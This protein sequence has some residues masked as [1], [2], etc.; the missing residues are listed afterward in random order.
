MACTEQSKPISTTTAKPPVAPARPVTDTYFGAQVTDP[1]RYMENLN[2]PEVQAWIKGQADYARHVLDSLPDRNVLLARIRELDAGAPYR[3]SIVHR[4]PNGD[5][6]YLKTMAKE[7][8]AKLYWKDGKTGEEKLLVDPEKWSQ[9]G[10]HFALEFCR[11]SPDGKFVAY[12]LAA[13]GS[14]QTVLHVLDVAAGKDVGETIANMESDYTPPSWLADSSGFVY[15]RRRDLPE[16]APATEVY[17]QTYAMLHKLNG[18]VAEDRLLLSM[19]HG[20]SGLAETDFPSVVLNTGSNFAIG[21]VKHGDANEL[22]LYCAP[23]SELQGSEVHWKKICDVSDEVTGFAVHGDDVY[24][25]TSAGA[26]RFK[27]VRVGLQN[28]EFAKG[29]VVVPAS[30]SVVESVSVG[31][32]ALYVGVLDAGMNRI[33]RLP[34]GAGAKAQAIELPAGMPSGYAI[35]VQADLDGVLVATSSWTRGGKLYSYDP[36]TNTLTDTQLQPPGKY[37]DLDEFESKEV[38]ARSYDGVKVPL[39]IIYKKGIKLDGSHPTLVSGYGGYGMVSSPHFSATSIAWL[40]RGGVLAHAHVRG[41]GEFGKEW[42]LAGQKKTKPNTWKDFIACCEYLVKE[43]YTSKAKLAGEGGSA[44]GIL[45]GRAVTER[46]DLFAAAIINVGCTDM[47][48]METTTNGVPNIPEFGSVTTK[49]GFEG[50]Y[51]MSTYVHVE[52][53]VKYPAILLT[54]GI[55]DPRVEPWMSAKLTAK[56]QADSASGKPIL[57]RVDYDAGHGI[58]STKRQRQE[59]Q[60]DQWAFLLWQMK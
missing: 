58:G 36:K 13:A 6:E 33:W 42:H 34:Y 29:E 43:G 21:K 46:P 22:T 40:E 14:E 18:K 35:S 4:W 56:L 12:G 30:E 53:G 2:D 11:P 7:N 41:G 54:H 24:L 38:M 44:G 23:V 52:K 32:D 19:K 39:S 25:V 59:Q 5:M 55:N 3:I 51:E 48:R 17:K 9:P 16:N 27:V 26:P 45:I 20:L 31:H 47:L 50:L 15:S 57:F 60:A 10:K 1:Y 49:E 37:D 8:L 28:P